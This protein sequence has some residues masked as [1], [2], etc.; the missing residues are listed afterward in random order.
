MFSLLVPLST[1]HIVLQAPL[2]LQEI[3]LALWLIV[4]GFNPSALAS[5]AAG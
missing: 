2:G 1:P 4:K 5:K 3:I